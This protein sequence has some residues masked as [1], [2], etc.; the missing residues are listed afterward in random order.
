M[1]IISSYSP[2]NHQIIHPGTL[3]T[4]KSLLLKRMN[5]WVVV[6]HQTFAT[7]TPTPSATSSFS[8]SK[9]LARRPPNPARRHPL[10]PH[11]AIGRS[12]RSHA[13]IARSEKSVAGRSR[14]Y[15]HRPQSE[16]VR[17]RP[18][19]LISREIAMSSRPLD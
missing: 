3:T 14:A 13:A 12:R 4:C 2:R 19:M 15:R 11:A 18:R 6:D 16:A 5:D 10:I 1:K 8:R 7:A 9:F 17:G